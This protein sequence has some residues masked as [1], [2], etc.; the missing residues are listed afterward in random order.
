MVVLSRSPR[1]AQY[2][3]WRELADAMSEVGVAV[4]DA[5]PL[6][7]DPPTAQGPL[8]RGPK[9]LSPHLPAREGGQRIHAP[10]RKEASTVSHQSVMDDQVAR[11][12]TDTVERLREAGVMAI[13]LHEPRRP[14][15]VVLVVFQV[16]GQTAGKGSA[17][18]VFDVDHWAAGPNVPAAYFDYLGDRWTPPERLVK[19]VLA[20]PVPNRRP[21]RPTNTW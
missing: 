19:S 3:D 2:L 10:R 18:L 16:G 1:V 8:A 9:P 17:A 20:I 4:A 7:A 14:E 21:H 6:R 12:V 5:V 11:P 15:M 13:R